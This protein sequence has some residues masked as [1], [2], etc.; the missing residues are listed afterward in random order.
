MGV[1]SGKVD[2]QPKVKLSVGED[3]ITNIR[4]RGHSGTIRVYRVSKGIFIMSLQEGILG[5]SF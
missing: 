4:N 5:N 2:L 3:N 1:P